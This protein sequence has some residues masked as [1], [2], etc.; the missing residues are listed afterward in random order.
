VALGQRLN[1][2]VTVRAFSATGSAINIT[3]YVNQVR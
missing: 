2:S 1:G 3:G